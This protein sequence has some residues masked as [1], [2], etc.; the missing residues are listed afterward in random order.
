VNFT[1]AA[2]TKTFVPS[3]LNVIGLFGSDLDISANNLPG[4]KTFPFWFISA[5]KTAFV[6]LSKSEPD[7]VI[8]SDT[9]IT[10]PNKAVVIGLLEIDL[11]TQLTASTKESRLA[12]NF[13]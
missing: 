10:I 11:E 6:E 2:L 8:S 7:N 12:T 9:S 4:T 13:I 1:L 3:K 5:L